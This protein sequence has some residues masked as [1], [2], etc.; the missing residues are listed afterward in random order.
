M[1]TKLLTGQSA[2]VTGATSGIGRGVAEAL[3]LAGAAVAVNYLSNDE[4]VAEEFCRAIRD[5][6]GKAVP[7]RADVSVESEVKR[8]VGETV[9]AFG[10]LDI[11]VANSGVQKDAAFRSMS[12]AD[13]RK[14]I[15]VNLTGSFLC[16]REVVGRFMDQ[17]RRGVSRAKGK[18]IFMSSVHE[19]IPWAGHANYAASKGGIHLLMQSL[20]QEVASE[21]IRVNSIAPGFI[22][23]PINKEAWSDEDK[24]RKSLELIPYGR[25]GEP[26][27]VA[28]A[29]V[30]LASDESD[31]VTGTTLFIDG[32]MALYPAF[33]KGG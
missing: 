26:E 7:V 32:G 14:V 6:G 13:W 11:L 19:R 3:A 1:N 31:Y 17:D 30:W 18:I 27:D 22:K 10:A 29:A 20:A 21:G 25:L 24:L 5:R 8:M 4:Q 15:D 9:S 33:Q 12:L 23:T 16:A 28:R 2:L